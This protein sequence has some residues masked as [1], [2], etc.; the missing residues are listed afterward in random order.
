MKNYD[1]Y[2]DIKVATFI[3]F[4]ILQWV[5]HV[6]RMVEQRVPQKAPQQKTQE[7]MGRRSERGCCR[8]T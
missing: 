8:V 4:R 3:K 2:K 6:I 5:G 1:L 7:N